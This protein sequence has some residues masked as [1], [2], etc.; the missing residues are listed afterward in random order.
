MDEFIHH[1]CLYPD[2]KQQHDLVGF[3]QA[4]Y[5]ACLEAMDDMNRTLEVVEESLIAR[6]SRERRRLENERGL[7]AYLAHERREEIVAYINEG[8]RH[9]ARSTSGTDG[10]AGQD[11]MVDSA[12]QA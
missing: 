8:R 7:R 2:T 6:S 5:E 10:D 3:R 11:T 9:L 1:L 12:T 4:V